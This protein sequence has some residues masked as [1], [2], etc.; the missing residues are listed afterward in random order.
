MTAAVAGYLKSCCLYVWEPANGPASKLATELRR[1]GFKVT[2]TTGDFLK[3]LVPPDDCI[4]AIVTETA[5]K[6]RA[7]AQVPVTAKL[8]RTTT[9][10]TGYAHCVLD[11]ETQ[12]S[13]NLT[14][15]GAARY[16]A[17]PTTTVLVVGFAIDNEP[18]EL[19]YPGL[20]PLPD[21]LVEV[22]A[23]P[24]VPFIAHNARFEIEIARNIL[25]PRYGLPEIAL[26]RWVCTM[27]TASA[28]AM[29]PDLEKL[30]LA[31]ELQAQK[32]P[33]G[34]RLMRRMSRPA[35][36][37]RDDTERLLA[38]GDYCKR[39]VE[40]TREAFYTLPALSDEEQRLWLL[41]QKINNAGVSFDRGLV[42]AAREIAELARPELEAPS[43]RRLT[44][45]SP[46]AIK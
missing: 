37:G 45:P 11:V 21:R 9:V 43:R 1:I 27:T 41:N 5:E 24:E 40:A 31:L 4:T 8:A 28:L 17:D 20:A 42:V 16:A 38:L 30:A 12:S 39:D 35:P 22:A 13:R 36:P 10:S 23:D 46:P 33:V 7:I 18:V 44:A 32:D 25:T 6:A 29:P 26:E 14:K 19:W 15:A 2:T 3:R 34:K